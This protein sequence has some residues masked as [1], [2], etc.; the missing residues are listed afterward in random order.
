MLRHLAF[1]LFVFAALFTGAVSGVFAD[2]EAGIPA[3][4]CGFAPMTRAAIE[5]EAATLTGTP[6]P[7]VFV[8]DA[9]DL[10]KGTEA[11]PEQVALAERTEREYAAC[12]NGA[13]WPAVLAMLTD[14]ARRLVLLDLV[15]EGVLSLFLDTVGTPETFGDGQPNP[16]VEIRVSGVRVL[17]DGRLAA[18]V[19]WRMAGTPAG[20]FSEVNFHIYEEVDGR[21]LLDEEISGFE[22]AGPAATPGA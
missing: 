21:L 15:E 9:A 3:T 14:D 1:G 6:T 16:I 13:N 12:Y 19:E 2:D 22:Y 4:E 20:S 17:P 8:D 10:P 5:A 7:S 18:I 11:P